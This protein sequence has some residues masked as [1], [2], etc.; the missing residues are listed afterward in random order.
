MA[1]VPISLPAADSAADAGDE[2]V[3]RR[4]ELRSR[5]RKAVVLPVSFVRADALFTLLFTR[6]FHQSSRSG[7]PSGDPPEHNVFA[8]AR[9]ELPALVHRNQTNFALRA[10]GESRFTAY[11][12]LVAC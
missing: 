4:V 11:G 12:F 1:D 10:R 3:G 2:R 6:A 8:R 9:K 5:A 7:N